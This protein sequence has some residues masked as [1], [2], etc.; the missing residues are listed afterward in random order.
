MLQPQDNNNP[1][2]QQVPGNLGDF[3]S[4]IQTPHQPDNTGSAESGAPL[5]DEVDEQPIQ[6]DNPEEIN[7][8]PEDTAPDGKPLPTAATLRLGD[9]LAKGCN[10][11]IP[12]IYSMYSHAP[13]EK[14]MIT[15]DELADLSQAFADYLLDVGANVTPVQALVCAIAGSFATQIPMVL[16]DRHQYEIQLKQQKQEDTTDNENNQ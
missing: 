16:A 4:S 9:A 6:F 12:G 3:M 11:A 13:A 2:F 10:K 7:T 8:D 5:F 14:Y 1:T 15:D